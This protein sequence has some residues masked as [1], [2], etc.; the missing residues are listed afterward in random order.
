MSLSLIICPSGI[1][2]RALQTVQGCN[3][4]QM[5]ELRKRTLKS[6]DPCKNA[7]LQSPLNEISWYL[8]RQLVLKVPE[9]KSYWLHSLV[10][11]LKSLLD[12]LLMKNIPNHPRKHIFHDYFLSQCFSIQNQQLNNSAHACKPTAF[13]WQD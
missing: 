9:P 10:H 5:K 7:R 12:A 1:I 3:V 11:N 13:C 2:T 6:L 4:P 8:G